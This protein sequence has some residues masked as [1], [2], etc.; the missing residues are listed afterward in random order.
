MS[1]EAGR[2]T[3]S[4]VVLI[5]NYGRFLGECLASILSQTFRDFEVILIDDASTD[6]SLEV[7]AR[8]SED[9]RVRVCPHQENR[10][11]V[12]SL[13]EGTEALST[14]EFLMVISADDLV[15]GTEAFAGQVAAMRENGGCVAAITGYAK[16]GPGSEYADRSLFTG[17][18]VIAAKTFGLR[19]LT[20]REFTVLHS[21]T[22]IRAESYRRAGGYRHDLTNYVDLAMWLSLARVGPV[23][24]LNGPLY[25]YRVHASQFSGSGS[26]RRAVLR[27]GLSLLDSEAREWQAHGLRVS[28]TQ[29]LRARVA[30]LALADAFAGRSVR[31][32]QRCVDAALLA[33][34]A[35]LT[36][37]GWW[38][39]GARSV[40][41]TGA[42]SVA[43]AA[44]RRLR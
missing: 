32:L 15:L 37:P 20:D 43:A 25:G 13:I 35:A 10:G 38:L 6:D 21:G 33:P 12:A 39:A 41:G 5:Y 2:P 30:D 40:L 26:R 29:V 4:V 3:L 34:V 9:P 24:Y 44:R 36:S 31:G 8:F 42:W 16:L 22:M 19:L 23:A 7:A 14:G 28:R 18:G 1:P 11:F 17:T 27:E